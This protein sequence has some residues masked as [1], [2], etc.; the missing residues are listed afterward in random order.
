MYK[1]QDELSIL[2]KQ[3]EGAANQ[4]PEMVYYTAML[5]FEDYKT[6]GDLKRNVRFHGA[7]NVSEVMKKH[8]DPWQVDLLGKEIHAWD[9]GRYVSPVVRDGPSNHYHW[10]VRPIGQSWDTLP[11][12]QRIHTL[13][14]QAS[15][16]LKRLYGTIGGVSRASHRQSNY[17]SH[18]FMSMR[19]IL[20]CEKHEYSF[21]QEELEYLNK[22]FHIALKTHDI[23]LLQKLLSERP[24][25]FDGIS[26]VFLKSAFICTILIDRLREKDI[27]KPNVTEDGGNVNEEPTPPKEFVT[28][29]AEQ[30]ASPKPAETGHEKK[31][32]GPPQSKYIF[33][34]QGPNKWLVKF[35][36]ETC[37][38]DNLVGVCYMAQL[39]ARKNKE[40]SAMELY[41]TVNPPP[42][43]ALKS[44][45]S[46]E[47]VMDNKYLQNCAKKLKELRIDLGQAKKDN[48]LAEVSRVQ[49]KIG[50]IEGVLSSGVG[51]RG[52]LRELS[53]DK[54]RV[55]SSVTMA[56][57]RAIK[58]INNDFPKLYQHLKNSIHTGETCSYK[59]DRDID[60]QL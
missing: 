52:R 14:R 19:D 51:L 37:T 28:A 49:Q 40:I 12:M 39:L 47:P 6:H 9:N 22:A 2:Q 36:E 58:P 17:L 16:I 11:A 46:T 57:N 20:I 53:N 27:N 48:D 13:T 5:S 18:W 24:P 33:R 8:I 29:E 21:I 26:D 4:F 10:L 38:L 55:R 50:Q 15:I 30:S 54:A 56:I 1:N 34:K 42:A 43:E 41:Q 44:P 3:F 45:A 25:T 31:T 60:W 7:E 23:E 32:A 59:P 35:E